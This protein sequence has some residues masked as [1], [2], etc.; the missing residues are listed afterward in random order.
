MSMSQSEHVFGSF[1]VQWSVD[2]CG[3]KISTKIS[4]MSQTHFLVKGGINMGPKPY[5]RP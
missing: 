3:W 1:Q 2:R 4:N 5:I